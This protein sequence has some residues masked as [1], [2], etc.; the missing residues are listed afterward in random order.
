MLDV[1]LRSLIRIAAFATAVAVL[2]VPA[3]A[4]IYH[5]TFDPLDFLGFANFSVGSN[6]LSPDGLKL[7]N[8]ITCTVDWLDATVTLTNSPSPATLTFSYGAFLPSIGAV[9]A[10]DILSGELTGVVSTP[11]GPV[12]IAGDPTPAFNGSFA[13]EFSHAIVNLY[14]D[15]VLA[16][17]ADARFTRVPEPGT[18]ELMLAAVG[19]AWIARRRQHR[20]P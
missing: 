10:V 18:L 16:A 15:G 11:I 1:K 17:T 3:H 12:V 9:T 6:C 7:N 5:S 13:L 14:R 20:T 8:G 2:A 4:A 19:V